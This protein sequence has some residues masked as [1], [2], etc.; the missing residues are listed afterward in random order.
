MEEWALANPL[1]ISVL[2][3]GLADAWYRESPRGCRR[4]QEEGAVHRGQ[5]ALPET[6]PF[7][8]VQHF[9]RG[10]VWRHTAN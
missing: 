3:L 8:G 7:A 4:Y 10:M 1:H 5:A 2:A 9:D 6:D